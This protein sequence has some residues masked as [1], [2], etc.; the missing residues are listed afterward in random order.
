MADE[1]FKTGLFSI[2]HNQVLGVFSLPEE[3]PG[4]T[5]KLVKCSKCVLSVCTRLHDH[6]SQFTKIKGD[7]VLCLYCIF[8]KSATVGKGCLAEGYRETFGRQIF[9]GTNPRLGERRNSFGPERQPMLTLWTDS[10]WVSQK[11]P[12]V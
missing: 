3:M 4:A 5:Q 12:R 2:S 10:E 11:S 7:S 9:G 1:G 8:F 6:D